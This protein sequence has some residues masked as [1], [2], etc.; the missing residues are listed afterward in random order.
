MEFA[1]AF[2][3]LY[4]G[5]HVGDYWV[6]TDH[7]ALHKGDAGGEGVYHCAMHVLTYLLTQLTILAIAIWSTNG[8]SRDTAWWQLPLALLIS[9]LTHY[10]ADRREYGLMFRLARRL[11]S[12][13]GLLTLGTSRREVYVADADDPRIQHAIDV[14]TL[15]T[16]AWALDQSWHL[17][18]GVF[19]P[20]LIIGA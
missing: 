14:P 17:A 6:Q 5:H 11:P 12:T 19:L 3:A 16:G 7:Q 2:I 15:G 9:G 18:L 10:T 8:W 20:A 13:K 4:V 1:I